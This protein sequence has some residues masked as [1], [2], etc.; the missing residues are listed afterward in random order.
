MVCFSKKEF[1]ILAQEEQYYKRQG[2][3]LPKRCKECREVNKKDTLQVICSECGNV[4]PVTKGERDYYR[5][6]G[7]K[8]PKRC[9]NCRGIPNIGLK[10]NRYFDGI[11]TYGPNINV[12]GGL[13]NSPGYVM[14]KMNNAEMR[15]STDYTGKKIT[16]SHTVQKIRNT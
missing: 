6:K 2:L 12:N 13:A 15:Y 3:H 5:S 9:P 14:E 10:R 7:F 8:M 4:F 11:Q 1:D 16:Y